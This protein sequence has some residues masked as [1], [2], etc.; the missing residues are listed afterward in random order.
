MLPNNPIEREC[1]VV[2][3]SAKPLPQVALAFERFPC[4]QG[5]VQNDLHLA[6]RSG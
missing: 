2:H 1:F 4:E 6:Q 3:V 5:Q